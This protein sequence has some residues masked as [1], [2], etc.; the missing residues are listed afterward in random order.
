MRVKIT[1]DGLHKITIADAETGDV[2][3]G[4]REVIW[5]SNLPHEI[6]TVELRMLF[7]NVEVIGELEA[8]E[9]ETLRGERRR[10]VLPVG[11]KEVPVRDATVQGD[12]FRHD[13]REGRMTLPH[14]ATILETVGD[15]PAPAL[16]GL[17]FLGYLLAMGVLVYGLRS[18]WVNGG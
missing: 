8:I 16:A 18:Q 13:G 9:V 12:E 14:L 4:V 15:V 17:L 10:F 1:S 11:T 6:P 3:K 7:T 5:K 2:L